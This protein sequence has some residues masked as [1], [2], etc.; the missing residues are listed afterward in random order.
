VVNASRAGEDE[1]EDGLSDQGH[2]L[3]GPQDIVC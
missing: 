3:R 2:L 1:D